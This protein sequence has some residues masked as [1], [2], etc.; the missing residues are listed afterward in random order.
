MLKKWLL[1]SLKI[2]FSAALIW[3]AVSGVDPEAAKAR[4]LQMA[5]EMIV[6]VVLAFVV[7][8]V[9]C[10][11]RWRTVLHTI[12]AP[13]AFVPGLRLFYIGSFFN[14]TLPASV[15][16]DAVRT[17]LTYRHGI[18]LRGALNG[19]MLER[20]A[21]VTGLVLLVAAVLPAF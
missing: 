10:T 14:Q 3:W 20:V 2:M 17:Y 19:V 15:G 8:F 12:G 6:P 11:F 21:T 9:I 4:I 7:Q 16:G 5:P 1:I 13:L 18:S